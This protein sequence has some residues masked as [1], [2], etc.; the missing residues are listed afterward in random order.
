MERNPY[1]Q[2]KKGS[3]LI[4]SPEIDP[5][6]FARS[7]ILL[8]EHSQA[9]SFGLIL[10]K[11]L[12]VDMPE[13]I[14]DLN[15]MTNPSIFVRAGGPIQTNQMMLLHDKADLGSTLKVC[16]NVF[17][18]GDLEFLQEAIAASD[19]PSVMLCFGYAGWGPGMLEREYLGGAWILSSGS[20]EYIFK[21]APEKLWRQVLRDKGGKYTGLSLIP[22]DLDLN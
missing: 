7:V 6:L 16:E 12:T 21:T 15:H 9:G 4:A 17:L 18:G 20:H 22:D 14:L 19:G 11:P 1:S 3:I 8:C 2:L 5:P 13:E 10:N